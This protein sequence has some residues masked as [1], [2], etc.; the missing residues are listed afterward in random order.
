MSNEQEEVLILNNL[1]KDTFIHADSLRSLLPSTTS[2]DQ[3]KSVRGNLLKQLKQSQ[4]NLGSLRNGYEESN[5]NL[6]V[7]KNEFNTAAGEVVGK[8]RYLHSTAEDTQLSIVQLTSEIKS[9]DLAKKNLTSSMTLLKRL[10]MLVTAY[11]KLRNLRQNRQ[12]GEA[13]SLMLATLQLLQYFKNYRSVERI[14]SLS[15][16]ITEFQRSFYEQVFE[17]FQLQFKK[18]SSIRGGFNA[19]SIETLH[20]LCGFIDVNGPNCSNALKNWY[21][22]HQLDGIFKVF[23]E[24]EEAGLLENFSRRYNWFFK[25]LQ[26]YDDQHVQI[27]PPHWRMDFQLC[28]LFC[29]ETKADLSKILKEKEISYEVFFTSIRHTL[30]F[31]NALKKRFSRLLKEGELNDQKLKL[32]TTQMFE[33]LSNE[34]NPYYKAY[35]NHEAKQL[36]TLFNSFHSKTEI[37]S[38]ETNQILSS[39]MQLFQLYRKIMGHF[40]Q[41]TRGP[42]LIGLKDLFSDWLRKYAEIELLADL[43]SLPFKQ[44][45]IRLNTAE[46]IHRTTLELEKR[47]QEICHADLAE[48][49]SFQKVIDFMLYSKSLLIKSCTKK[50]EDSVK[51]SLEPFGKLDLRNLDSVGDQSAYVF[52]AI[53]EMKLNADEFLGTIEQN[54]LA[55][56]FCDRVCESFTKQFFYYIYTIKPVSEIGAEQILLDLCSFKNFLLKMPSSKPD[57]TITDSYI[58][59][60]TIF[61]GYIE[62]LLKTLLTPSLP[63]EGIIQSYLF[64][65]KDRSVSNFTIVLDLKGVSK[66]EQSSYL[67]LFS[68]FVAKKNDLS[69]SSP[70]FLYL[71]P[72]TYTDM[73]TRSRLSLE[74]TPDASSR[75][76]QNLGRLF[77]SKKKYG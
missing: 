48:E 6:I 2:I 39:S 38:E 3:L 50:Y 24:N 41:F 8:L 53:H 73:N 58:N 14:A 36:D 74:L 43:S 54:T 26:T 69:D 4:D 55:R 25:L 70:I 45:A 76:L 12:I 57:Y 18:A 77:T 5:K 52:T 63:K 51:T 22:H 62:T 35:I 9:L 66:S 11:E 46:Y 59:H 29:N 49:M 47:F 19:A 33:S 23:R 75:T 16:N 71:S 15:Q 21:C 31:Q 56:N 72:S 64:L 40:L 68:S 44:Y 37:S 32:H 13:T 65:I 28:M 10:Q 60:L 34:F 67:Q 17:N 7:Q 27:F 20:E 42:P 1:G 61:M 30:D